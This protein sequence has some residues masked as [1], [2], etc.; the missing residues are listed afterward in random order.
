MPGDTQ[1]N[2]WNLRRML[3]LLSGENRELM[4]HCG[5]IIKF[6]IFLAVIYCLAGTSP[7]LA[8]SGP[9][10]YRKIKIADNVVPVMNIA[11]SRAT[12]EISK[13]E[14]L[15]DIA[16]DYGLGFN[17]L[18]LLY[19]EMDPWL[20]P[21]G[22]KIDIPL[23]WVLPPIRLE[24]VV[25]NIPEM[26][27]YRFFPENKLVKTYPV[28]IAKQGMNTP[29]TDTKV[30][31]HIK[32]PNWTDPNDSRNETDNS[33][34]PPG[35]SNPLGK[36]WIGL[37]VD[38]IG[39]HGTNFAWS[40]GRR[41]SQGCIR[42]YP[43]DVKNFFNEALMGTRVEIIYEP[44]KVGIRDNEIFVEV[45]P[46]INDVFPDLYERAI[47]LLEETAL[48]ADVDK[49]KLREAVVEQNGMPRKV[50]IIAKP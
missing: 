14:T 38:H 47:S 17:D 20:P 19:P 8:E 11:G 2:I 29:I 22:K 26:R 45:H 24:A 31:E 12:H 10:K 43:E 5:L 36:R 30:A 18:E 25:I 16:R 9:F 42:M 3:D 13:Q 32:N 28:G 21:E 37:G 50:G 7:V 1:D 49:E 27:L 46:D 40:I 35:Q 34:V 4:I 44:V 23:M 48:L 6:L 33:V 15:L 41:V 39:I